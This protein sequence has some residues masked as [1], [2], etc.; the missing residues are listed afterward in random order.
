MIRSRLSPTIDR[1]LAMTFIGG[2]LA[3]LAD[4][5]ITYLLGDIFNRFDDLMHYGGFG[6]LGAEYFA[7]KLPLIV[8]QVLPVACLA[9]AL[10]GLALLARSNEILACQQLGISRL[11]MAAP[12]L[13]L[14]VLISLVDFGISETI[15]PYTTREARY[16]YEVQL[17]KR[18][19]RAVFA[20]QHIWVRVNDGFMSAETWDKSRR[21]LH[22]VTIYRLGLNYN[23][24]D[25]LH[26]KSAIWNGHRWVPHHLTALELKQKGNVVPVNTANFHIGVNPKDFS[27][28]KLDPDEFS[29]WELDA[30]IKGLRDKGLDPGGY[31]VDRDLKYAMPL[32]CL[33]MVGLGLVLSLDPLPRH[34]SLGKSFGLA[35]AIGFGYWLSLGITSSL[36]HSGLMPAWVAAWL[37]NLLFTMIAMSLFLLGEEH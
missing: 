34:L 33:I 9:G 6:L 18:E 3:C 1:F 7:L 22:G 16:L 21:E 15:V 8:S 12:L 13:L 36:G 30:S 19:L 37:P 27:L 25:I 17:K 23:L 32:S 28:L 11:E 14:A 4:F 26:A 29:L 5:T 35:I 24:R 20:N 10:L 31:V 2:F